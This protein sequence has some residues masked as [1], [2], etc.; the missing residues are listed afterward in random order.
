M[1]GLALTAAA[2]LAKGIAGGIA[3]GK[4]ARAQK[5]AIDNQKAKNNAWYERNYYQDYLDTSMA[6]SSMK[7]VEDTLRRNNQ[8]TNAT[9]AITGATPEAVEAS[10]EGNQKTLSDTVGNLASHNDA[11]KDS[12]DAVNLQNQNNITQQKIGQYQADEQAGA[13]LEQSGIEGIGSAL[14]GVADE[15]GDNTEVNGQTGALELSD[16]AKQQA[17]GTIDL[18][19]KKTP[20]L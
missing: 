6:K 15:T 20:L 3:S 7:R 1:I 11:R 13:S 2:S 8:E 12:I 4:A 9:A 10:L 14:S 5:R 19:N 16:A 18:I 17:Q